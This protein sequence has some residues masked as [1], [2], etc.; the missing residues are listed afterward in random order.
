MKQGKIPSLLKVVS[1]QVLISLEALFQTSRQPELIKIRTNKA[2]K[3][4]FEQRLWCKVLVLQEHHL[5]ISSSNYYKTITLLLT[6]AKAQKLYSFVWTLALFRM[7]H[8]EQF[9]TPTE[10]YLFSEG[11]D[12]L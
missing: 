8:T 6:C 5:L 9:R 7:N 4:S 3:F 12:N 1:F 11:L 10:N 2:G